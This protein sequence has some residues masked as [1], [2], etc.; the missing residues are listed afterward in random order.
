MTP[1]REELE[2][3]GLYAALRARGVRLRLAHQTIGARHA[4]AA[5]A[6][7]LL[8]PARATLL[9]MQRLAIADNGTVVEYGDHIYR[10]SRYSFQTS[11]V[12]R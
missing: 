6:R 10:A 11:L 4:T 7:A 5:E 1:T 2:D 3:G 8:E 12:A 9:T